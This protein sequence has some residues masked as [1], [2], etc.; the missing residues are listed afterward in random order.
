MGLFFGKRERLD[1]YQINSKTHSSIVPAATHELGGKKEKVV[2][3][4]SKVYGFEDAI[5]TRELYEGVALLNDYYKMIIDA[6]L[7]FEGEFLGIFA[8]FVCNVFGAPIRHHNDIRRAARCSLEIQNEIKN[9]N[10][11]RTMRGREIMKVGMAL[12]TGDVLI[13]YFGS[14][15]RMSYAAMG[16]S[17][18]L[19]YKFCEM[20]E[21][22]QVLATQGICDD[23]KDLGDVILLRPYRVSNTAKPIPVFQIK[24]LRQYHSELA[25]KYTGVA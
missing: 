6:T 12:S 15:R 8:G 17:V 5:K 22:G 24:N 7:K 11:E 25:I 4:L 21:P 23:I 16:E 2:I 19:C 13:G 20:A 1:K 10:D 14:S 9:F 3:F 18:E